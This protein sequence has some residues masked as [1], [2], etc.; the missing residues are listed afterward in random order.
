MDGAAKFIRGD[1]ILGLALT[2]I[3]LIGGVAVGLRGGLGAA[4][5]GAV[6]G[7]RAR[8]DGLLAQVPAL[9]VGLAAALLVARV[10]GEE[11]TRRQAVWL[12]PGVLAAPAGLLAG[13]ALAPGMPREAF[14]I[15]AAGLGA[16][17]LG[18]A[19]ARL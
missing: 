12:T 2:A 19:R 18:L 15:I 7:R 4:G 5:A 6:D 3:N 14:I 8:G 11:P 1:A 16:G 13:L 9:L 10:D 17:A